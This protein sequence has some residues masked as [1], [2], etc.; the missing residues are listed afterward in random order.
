MSKIKALIQDNP[1]ITLGNQKW[2]GAAPIF[3]SIVELIIKFWYNKLFKLNNKLN[4]IIYIIETNKKISEAKVWVK[5]Y[6][7]ADS[8]ERIFLLSIIRGINDNKLISNPIHIPSQEEDEIEIIEP[9]INVDK[10]VN[11]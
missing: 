8:L 4:F 6:L 2:N 10:N 1:S 5:K 3:N 9:A 11:L 7:I